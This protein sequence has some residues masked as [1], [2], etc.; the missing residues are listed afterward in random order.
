[1][2]SMLEHSAINADTTLCRH[3]FSSQKNDS[4]PAHANAKPKPSTHKICLRKTF[5]LNVLKFDHSM[6]FNHALRTL[7]FDLSVILLC[8]GP[9]WLRVSR[10][11]HHTSCGPERRL[12]R[13]R[14]DVSLCRATGKKSE[15]PS[16][17]SLCRHISRIGGDGRGGRPPTL[18]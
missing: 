3:P 6:R 17:R 18:S 11:Q 9:N 1:M 16:A 2:C 13:G 14:G 5:Y 4:L 10:S 15:A 7:D 8:S 12:A